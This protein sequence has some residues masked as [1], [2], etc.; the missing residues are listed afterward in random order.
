MRKEE[1]MAGTIRE[2]Y[3]S[4][5]GKVPFPGDR[6]KGFPR[7]TTPGSGW[8]HEYKNLSSVPGEKLLV[9]LVNREVNRGGT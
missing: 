2:F 7:V 8:N 3:R 9:L 4:N 6:W 5:P 1:V